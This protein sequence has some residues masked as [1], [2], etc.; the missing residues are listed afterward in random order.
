[1]PCP[2]NALAVGSA[3]AA[4]VADTEAEA[5]LVTVTTIAISATIRHSPAARLAAAASSRS[6]RRARMR[7]GGRPAASPAACRAARWRG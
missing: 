4:T 3:R 7:S 5:G 6:T 1:M 2:R